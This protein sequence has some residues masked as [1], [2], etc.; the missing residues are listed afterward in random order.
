MY[1]L[2]VKNDER[3]H[4]RDIKK[5][6]SRMYVGMKASKIINENWFERSNKRKT[7]T[8]CEMYKE[9]FVVCW[10]GAMGDELRTSYKYIDLIIGDKDIELRW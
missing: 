7:V 10:N 5:L 4:L 9:H 1:V 3:L 6:R 2:T 8:V